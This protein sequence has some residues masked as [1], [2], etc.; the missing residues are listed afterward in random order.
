[1]SSSPRKEHG[2]ARI[3]AR[4]KALKSQGGDSLN[5]IA[6]AELVASLMEGTVSLDEIDDETLNRCLQALGTSQFV[7]ALRKD[8]DVTIEAEQERISSEGSKDAKVAEV[9]QMPRSKIRAIHSF[10][11]WN[12]NVAWVAAAASVAFVTTMFV[13]EDKS[14]QVSQGDPVRETVTFQWPGKLPFDAAALN[15]WGAPARLLSKEMPD[16]ERGGGTLGAGSEGRFSAWQLG[17][18]IIRTEE[19]IG[20]GTFISADGWLLTN[21]HVIEG[22]AQRASLVG[23]VPSVEVIIGHQVNGR[24]RPRSAIKAKLYRVDPARDLALLKLE[25]LPEGVKGVPFF[26][27]ASE[28]REGEECFVIGARGNG[29]AWWIRSGNVSGI[30]DFP[31]G[32]NQVVAGLATADGSVERTRARMVVTDIRI[33]GGDSGGPLLNRK[34]E[35]IGLT[36]AP[37]VARTSGSVGWHIAVEHLR[38][39]VS[40]L[41]NQPE[42]VPFDPWTAGLPQV[43]LGVP[44]HVDGDRDGRI[45][46][47]FY[48]YSGDVTDNVSHTAPQPLAFT[49][50]IDFSQRAQAKPEVPDLIPTGLWSF[51]ARGRF[52][53]DVFI[54][55]RSDEVLAVGYT[56]G[57]GI[58]DEIR[59]GSAKDNQVTLVWW[60]EKQGQWRAS[61]PPRGTAFLDAMRV[62]GGNRQR[63]GEIY[64]NL[65]GNQAEGRSV[66]PSA[67]QR[68]EDRTTRGPN[69]L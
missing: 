45:D 3:R 1:M 9:I 58:V 65:V 55:V 10:S 15:A 59:I 22:E 35:L 17:T 52:R 66:K 13:W 33:S 41:P 68:S 20:S 69:K 37:P 24:M 26:G 63:I 7:K 43:R 36:F 25:A 18:V 42:G 27:L 28:V 53:H 56:N 14:P 47:L 38:G 34:G 51:E 4:A 12:R 49:I 16:F 31:S 19:G 6:D 5:D 61:R 44:Q 39:I 62:S 57:D 11:W 48:R 67:P 64:E 21:Y 50:F 46:T 29:P 40:G 60:R 54:T 23:E 30:L 32:R 8:T 2:I